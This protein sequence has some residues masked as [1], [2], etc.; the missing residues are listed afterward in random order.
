VGITYVTKA[1]G[2]KQL[3]D[4]RK[5][6]SLCLRLDVDREVAEEIVRR[7]ENQLYDGVETRKILQLVY[8]YIR[9]YKPAVRYHI[10]LR[11]AIS[12]LRPKP[13]FERFIQLLLQEYGYEV[14]PNVIVRGKCVEHEIDA[15]AVKDDEAILVEVKHHFNHHTYTGLDICRE[16]RATYEDV[17]EGY[18][19]GFNNF[20]ITKVM[21]VCNTKFSDHAKQYSKCRG[22]LNLGWKSPSEKGL[23]T[24]IKE[25]KFYPIT[26][27]KNLRRKDRDK[28]GDHG[29]ILLKQLARYTPDELQKKTGI[30]VDTAERIIKEAKETL[31]T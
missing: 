2:R 7:I 18:E 20:N 1:D 3:Y 5:I 17:T 11:R 24:M 31:Q 9:R 15:M 29:I 25:K 10:D 14:I 8:R 22:I 23:E 12:L 13:D 6:I 26:L 27:L 21:I 30:T 4:R 19:L 28:L 16:A